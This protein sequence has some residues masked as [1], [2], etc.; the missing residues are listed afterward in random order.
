M[1]SGKPFRP[2][3]AMSALAATAA[4]TAPPSGTSSR[5]LVAIALI[6]LTPGCLTRSKNLQR[7]NAWRNDDRQ[8]FFAVITGKT[9][10][11][12]RFRTDSMTIILDML[13]VEQRQPAPVWRCRPGHLPPFFLFPPCEQRALAARMNLVETPLVFLKY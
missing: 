7:W 9:L 2:A 10:T 1:N 6:T 5:R 8:T 12:H 11:K 3:C 13:G 4:S